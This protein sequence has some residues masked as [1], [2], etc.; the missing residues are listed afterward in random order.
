MRRL[1]AAIVSPSVF[2]DET[3]S[4]SSLISS[5]QTV[6]SQINMYTPNIGGLT[7]NRAESS[8]NGRNHKLDNDHRTNQPIHPI[9][10]QSQPNLLPHTAVRP[11]VATHPK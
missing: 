9:W 4:N 7:P 6:R 10:Y 8:S 5:K 3:S 1:L 2:F 11:Q